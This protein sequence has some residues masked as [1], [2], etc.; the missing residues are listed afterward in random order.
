M[1]NRGFTLIEVIFSLGLIAIIALSTFSSYQFFIRSNTEN[2]IRTGAMQAAQ[3]VLDSIRAESI[4]SLPGS[5]TATAQ[6]TPPRTITIAGRAR[7]YSVAVT[8]CGIRALCTAPTTRHIKVEVSFDGRKRY[9]TE[10]V[11]SDL[12]G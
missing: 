4:N 12:L 3:Q 9:E 11:F 6:E 1:K 5:S 7:P 8:Y 2:E 10:S